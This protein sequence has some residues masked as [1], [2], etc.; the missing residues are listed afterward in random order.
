MKGGFK[1]IAQTVAL[2]MLIISFWFNTKGQGLSI[3]ATGVAADNSAMLDVSSNSQGVLVPR[4][5]ASNRMGISSPATGLLVYQT[6]GVSGFYFYNGTDWVS[7]NSSTT[8]ITGLGSNLGS[9]VNAG[10]AYSLSYT[11]R[12]TD[13]IIWSDC[14]LC[15]F[16]LPAANSVPPGHVIY[17]Y[18]LGASYNPGFYSSNGTDNFYLFT[19]EAGVTSSLYIG[20]TTSYWTVVVSDGSSNWFVTTHN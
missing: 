12:T 13:G 9:A 4:M 3:N 1:A 11:V 16:T 20:G 14:T 8:T 18:N 17:F 2:L 10:T 7:L 5:T 15:Y 6:N 19:H